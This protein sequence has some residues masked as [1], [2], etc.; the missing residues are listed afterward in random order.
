MKL[1]VPIFLFV[2]L[3]AC[4]QYEL[5]PVDWGAYPLLHYVRPLETVLTEQG[6]SG[7]EFLA[8]ALKTS[9]TILQSHSS[10]L[11]VRAAVGRS[12]I[13]P[14]PSLSLT[15]DYSKVA[16]SASPWLYGAALGLP[17]EMVKRRDVL[18]RF[19]DLEALQAYYAHV[20][21]LWA[22]YSRV[23]H[24]LIERRTA[25][26]EQ[27]VVSELVLARS[28]VLTLMEQKIEAGE[29]PSLAI[30]RMKSTLAA[31]R[32][33]ERA[34]TARRARANQILAQ[35][36][37]VAV[38]Q[39]E[40]LRIIP[41][42]DDVSFDPTDLMT[43][44]RDAVLLRKDVLAAVSAYDRADLDLRRAYARQYPQV[45]LGPGYVWDHRFDRPPLA[46]GLSLPPYDL[47]K[48]AI[49]QA[50]ARRAEAAQTLESNQTAVL[51][52]VDQAHSALTQAQEN[53]HQ[54]DQVDLQMARKAFGAAQIN[55]RFGETD[56]LDFAAAK[57][58]VAEATLSVIE[59]RYLVRLA[60]AD[61]EDALRRPFSLQD[62]L[63]LQSVT[64]KLKTAP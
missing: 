20:D 40:K 54:A 9:P 1:L 10:V 53:L 37:G 11:A 15:A 47:N 32:G 5:R 3:G 26:E 58:A 24:G 48:T 4:A 51:A 49:T 41:A 21:A 45:Q 55:Y 64:D 30:A 60:Q 29:E 43:W 42:E 61:L 33:L 59:A 63:S 27:Q 16:V 12:R 56:E 34:A 38:D 44:R 39:V 50:D 18:E 52:A 36:L 6:Q 31:A 23:K 22:T 57:A 8:Q 13:Y 19:S 17:T 28:T 62:R 46:L 2:Q 14:A 25:D 7:S 35:E